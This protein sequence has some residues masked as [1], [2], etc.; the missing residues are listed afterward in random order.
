M[1]VSMVLYEKHRF[2]S[3][4][5]ILFFFFIFF[6]VWS[7]WSSEFPVKFYVTS[8]KLQYFTFLTKI[9][10][11]ASVSRLVSLRPPRLSLARL[12]YPWNSPGKNT[13]VDWHSLLQGI[14]PTQVLNPSLLLCRQILYHLSHR[15]SPQFLHLVKKKMEL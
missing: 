15:R 11:H 3:R 7:F 8:R 2:G 6:C 10:T 4:P 5:V 9:A 13:G 12:L 14:F 1:R